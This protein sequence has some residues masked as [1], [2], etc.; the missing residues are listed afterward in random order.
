MPAV[1][2]HLLAQLIASEGLLLTLCVSDACYAS[3][4][5][6]TAD[7]LGMFPPDCLCV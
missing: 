7:G 5:S 6:V 3:S 4:L 2:D 1:T